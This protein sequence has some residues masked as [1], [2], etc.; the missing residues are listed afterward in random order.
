MNRAPTVSAAGGAAGDLAPGIA[1]RTY[2]G[3]RGGRP[4]IAGSGAGGPSIGV[5]YTGGI[6]NFI[7][8]ARPKAGT[9]GA[10]ADKDSNTFQD[11]TWILPAS[12]PGIA[13]DMHEF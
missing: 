12:D 11:V 9:P 3:G 1:G 4:G 6:P 8:A 2:P 10:G 5:A 7:N 13:E